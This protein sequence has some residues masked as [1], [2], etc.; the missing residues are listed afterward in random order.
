MD[1]FKLAHYTTFN[2]FSNFYPDQ[3][4][5]GSSIPIPSKIEYH[6]P[7]SIPR[8]EKETTEKEQIGIEGG[9]ISGT[10][11][12]RGQGGDINKYGIKPRSNTHGNTQNLQEVRER[13]YHVDSDNRGPYRTEFKQGEQRPGAVK[14]TGRVRHRKNRNPG[15]AYD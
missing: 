6:E 1:P 4:I 5:R 7:Y 10:T 13:G 14:P 2:Q 9:I 3:Y 12:R 8:A 15:I 11:K